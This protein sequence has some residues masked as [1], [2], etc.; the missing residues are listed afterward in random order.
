MLINTDK[1]IALWHDIKDQFSYIESDTTECMQP[2]LSHSQP[3]PADRTAFW[4][5]YA[6]NGFEKAMRKRYDLSRLTIIKRNIQLFFHAIT[7]KISR[8]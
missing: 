8:I 6:A 2:V 7:A 5:D 4:Q 3:E 1:G